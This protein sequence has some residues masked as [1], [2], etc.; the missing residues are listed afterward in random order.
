MTNLRYDEAANVRKLHRLPPRLRVAFALLPAIRLLPA[1]RRYHERT[2]QGDPDALRALVEGLWQDLGTGE[3]GAAD[4]QGGLDRCM[5]L[6]PEEEEG[7]DA[8]TQPQAED[9]VAAAAYAWRARSTGE[10]QEA[11]WA[12]RRAYEALDQFVAS[13]AAEPQVSAESILAHPL[14]QAELGRQQRDLETLAGLAREA[15]PLSGL[16]G[17]RRR[18]EQEADSVFGEPET[19]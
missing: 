1:Y 17:L 12:G 13:L 9:A 10:A 8:E 16:T 5:A 4:L 14:V 18:S 7:W 2:G 6:M 11:A 19:T 15:D 3:M